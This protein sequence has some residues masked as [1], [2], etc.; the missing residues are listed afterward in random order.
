MV[1][2]DRRRTWPTS[3]AA[4]R[5]SALCGPRSW[6]W[7]MSSRGPDQFGN[8]LS[9]SPR[10]MWMSALAFVALKVMVF[11][12]TGAHIILG[13]AV[14]IQVIRRDVHEHGHCGPKERRSFE[15]E[16]VYLE[17]KKV[18]VFGLVHD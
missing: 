16:C 11:P 18:Q 2:S 10:S 3:N 1:S 17:Q 13:S 7:S 4:M 14:T 15:L 12:G 9:N 6:Q 8:R 5:F